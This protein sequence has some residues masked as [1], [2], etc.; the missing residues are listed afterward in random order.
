MY[1]EE[2]SQQEQKISQMR[3]QRA[4]EYDI[5]KQVGLSLSSLTGFAPLQREK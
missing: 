4:D 1:K 3:Q 5:K 2:L